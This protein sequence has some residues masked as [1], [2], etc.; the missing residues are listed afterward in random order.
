MGRYYTG[1]IEGKFT[2]A[3]Q[4]SDAANRFGVEGHSP[5]YLEYYFDKDNLPELKEE[6]KNIENT[7]KEHKR[8]LQ[9]YF[10]LYG[11][12]QDAPL[13]FWEYLKKAEL[14]EL[15]EEQVS[16]YVDYRLGRQILK[17]IEE[18]GECTFDAE[19]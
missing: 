9:I 3:V 19:L 18:H 16:E 13:S 1:D 11:T 5:S 4:S 14:P 10:D 15:I 6:L 8:A 2:F 17:C 7:F 12:E